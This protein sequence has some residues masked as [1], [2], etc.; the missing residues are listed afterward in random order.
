MIHFEMNMKLLLLD[1][2]LDRIIIFPC[3]FWCVAAARESERRLSTLSP[4]SL[5]QQ[6]RLT[7]ESRWGITKI[8]SSCG[9]T[10]GPNKLTPAFLLRQAR[11]SSAKSDIVEVVK[12][13]YVVS[14]WCATGSCAENPLPPSSRRHI[15]FRQGKGSSSRWSSPHLPRPHVAYGSHQFTR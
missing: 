12:N 3:F 11:T 8:G 6:T 14:V 15:G 13:F 9:S 2:L 5:A 7:T 10:R 4:D 1:E